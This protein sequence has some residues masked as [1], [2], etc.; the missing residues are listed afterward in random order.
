MPEV[1]IIGLGPVGLATALGLAQNGHQVTGVDVDKARIGKLLRAESPVYEVG[2]EE[3]LN[4]ALSRKRFLPTPDITDTSPKT[5]F[6]F[7][8]VGT[9]SRADGSMDDYPIAKATEEV[10]KVLPPDQRPIVVV[11]ST[12]VPGTTELIIIPILEASGKPFGVA[13]N[14]EFLREG[15]ALED[16]LRPDRIAMGFAEEET[17]RRLRTL[18]ESHTCPKVETNLRTAEA[19]KHVSNAFLATKVGFAN[20][21]ANLCQRLGV[22]YD[23]VMKGVILDDRINPKFLVPGVGFGGSCFPNDLQAL[24]AAG[25]GAGYAPPLLEA[26][27]RHNERQHL[28]ALRLLEEELGSLPGRR[29]AILGLAFK[30]DTDDVR[31][32]RALL[33]ARDLQDRGANVVG[34]D[35]VAS[36][37]FRQLMPDVHLAGSVAEALA[38][39]EGCIVQAEWQEFQE[40]G[41][42]DFLKSM[43]TPVV[44]DGRRILDPERME[45]V[46]FRRIG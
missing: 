16:T 43:R 5:E 41:A 28:E 22:S 20:E 42:E 29:I 17:G 30:G 24:V 11:K 1:A 27:I 26:V 37:K 40:L 35:P 32:S 31:E 34:F 18:Y 15:H 39:A 6:F 38:G 13:V 21:M 36:R 8:C 19:I 12:V 3:E 44:V 23:E 14:P 2:M 46:R 7:L 45:G 9:P 4:R 10:A 33:L 25:R